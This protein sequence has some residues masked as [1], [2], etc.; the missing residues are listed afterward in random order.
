MPNYQKFFTEDGK[1]D[2]IMRNQHPIAIRIIAAA[3]QS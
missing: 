2:T 1:G 3:L